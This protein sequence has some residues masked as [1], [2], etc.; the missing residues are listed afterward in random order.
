MAPEAPAEL[1]ELTL[2][3]AQRGE[4]SACRAL[5]LR[6]ERP[7][8]ALLSRLLGV[9][10]GALEDLA[11]ETFLRAFRALPS[12]DRRGPAR[13]STWLLTIATR[14]GLDEMR[15][16]PTEPLDD[17]LPAPDRTDARSMGPALQRAIAQLS[18]DHRAAFLLREAHELSYEEIAAALQIELGTVKSRIAR[19]KD[20]LRAALED[21]HG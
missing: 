2:T 3:R 1:D 19:A 5:V 9:S 18:P 6:Y 20:A 7:V 16:R 10:H 17:Q 21:P 4:E 12:F 13:L 8:F 15:R 11:Q 14:L